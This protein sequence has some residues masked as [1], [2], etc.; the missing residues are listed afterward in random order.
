MNEGGALD[1]SRTLHRARRRSVR[2]ADALA[3][4]ASALAVDGQDTCLLI[5]APRRCIVGRL[6]DAGTVRVR[7]GRLDPGDAFEARAFSGRG[8]LR[9]LRDDVG[10]SA[11]TAIL[12]LGTATAVPG[13]EPLAPLQGLAAEPRTYLL[14][15]H[16]ERD[17]TADPPGWM[18]LY[19]PAIGTL[20]LPSCDAGADG[21]VRLQA[22]E[23]LQRLAPHGNTVVAEE[24]LIGFGG[25]T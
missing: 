23:Y 8:E 20:T 7:E 22:V 14:W 6:D 17:V 5:Y 13:F 19:E 3:A 9:W 16:V 2:L 1:Y 15:G 25:I 12:L 4:A 24:V 21:R 18:R 10:A 11:G